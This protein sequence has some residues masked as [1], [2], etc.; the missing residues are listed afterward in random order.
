MSVSINNK[1]AECESLEI[2]ANR[3][4]ADSSPRVSL[5]HISAQWRELA[6][7]NPIKT[8]RLPMWTEQEVECAKLV[9]AAL[10]YLRRVQ[11]VNI[12][13]LINDVIRYQSEQI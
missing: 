1:A 11:C 5:N 10:T 8:Q 9:M 7:S 3:I 13:K 4:T 12:E 2:A 6:R